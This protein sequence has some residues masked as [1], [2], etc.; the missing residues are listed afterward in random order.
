MQPFIFAIDLAALAARREYLNLEKWLQDKIAEQGD[1]FGQ[2]CLNLLSR[3]VRAELARQDANAALRTV[4]L[5]VEVVG[6]FI[7][8]LLER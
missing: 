6:V 3:K 4:P 5:S 7:K 1:V 8:V 2:A